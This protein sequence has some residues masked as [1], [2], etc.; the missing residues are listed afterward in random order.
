MKDQIKEFLQKAPYIV[1][2]AG[3]LLYIGWTDY[4]QFE[5]GDSSKKVAKINQIKTAQEQV[6]SLNKKIE[7]AQEFMA[8]LSAKKEQMKL[9][10][11]KLKS[12][13]GFLSEEI[14]E[15]EFL[16]TISREAKKVGL[17]ISSLVPG[18]TKTEEFFIEKTFK[19]DFRGVFVQVLVFMEKVS[20]LKEITRIGNFTLE[21]DGKQ[22]VK[23]VDL[24]GT[25]EI[26]TYQYNSSK[27]DEVI[28]QLKNKS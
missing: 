26:L 4:Y 15:G 2:L 22:D 16:R 19:L 24:K 23:F 1:L 25:L 11:E 10:G 5:F 3:Y 28:R 20:S 12:T 9:L 21:V 18:E 17:R 7:Q 13:Q 27:A 8:S 6:V 14:N